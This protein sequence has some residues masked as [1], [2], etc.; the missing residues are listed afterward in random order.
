MKKR[1][2]AAE[3]A[4]QVYSNG[5][6]EWDLFDRYLWRRVN[7]GPER[8]LRVSRRSGERGSARRRRGAR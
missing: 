5:T 1:R 3:F 8:A 2:L 4:I 6:I 7:E